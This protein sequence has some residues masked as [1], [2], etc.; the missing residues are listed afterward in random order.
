MNEIDP[1]PPRLSWHCLMCR[2]QGTARGELAIRA[3]QGEHIAHCLTE[4]A[5]AAYARERASVV[6]GHGP[7]DTVVD[8]PAQSRAVI[9]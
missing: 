2:F 7:R 5:R 9:G 3:V 6:T 8:Q 1:P 4:H